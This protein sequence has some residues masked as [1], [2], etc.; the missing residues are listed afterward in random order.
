MLVYQRVNRTKQENNI[1]NT[2]RG[3]CQQETTIRAR[4]VISPSWDSPTSS[5]RFSQIFPAPAAQLLHGIA[6]LNGGMVIVGQWSGPGP[7]PATEEP[8]E[9]KRYVCFTYMCL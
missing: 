6:K 2:N 1:H 3:H 4:F 5:P 8:G 7:S 9:T